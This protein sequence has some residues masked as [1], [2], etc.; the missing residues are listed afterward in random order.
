MNPIIRDKDAELHETLQLARASVFRL[1]PLTRSINYIEQDTASN[2]QI[3]SVLALFVS[4]HF[5]GTD[6]ETILERSQRS[7][8][9]S[10]YQ[11][12]FICTCATGSTVCSRSNKRASSTVEDI[13]FND[14][15][16]KSLRSI[17]R[18][19]NSV[20]VPLGTLR[21]GVCRHRALLM[22]VRCMSLQYLYFYDVHVLYFIC[23][24]T[25]C[26]IQYLCDRMDPPVPCELVRGYLDF[27]RHAWNVILIKK[28]DSWIRMLV[29]SCRP[30]DIREERDPEFFSR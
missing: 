6:R 23:L 1:K 22:K 10:E 4:N 26:Q 15:C 13:H 3:A 30:H 21:F 17:K 24:L 12:P 11:K 27:M 8:F 7:V 19:R 5:G 29:D 2:L 16:E 25:E 18:R 28:G 20:V 9:T 14:I